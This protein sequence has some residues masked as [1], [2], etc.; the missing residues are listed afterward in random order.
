MATELKIAVDQR[1]AIALDYAVQADKS[2][3]LE[4][5]FSSEY[6]VVRSYGVEVLDHSPGCADLTRANTG[7][8]PLLRNH[9]QRELIG[10][11][12]RAWVDPATRKGRALVRFDKGPK[13][14]EAQRQVEAKILGN[15]SFWYK[16]RSYR[17]E[18]PDGPQSPPRVVIDKWE[19]VEISLVSCPDDPTVG[20]GRSAQPV[21]QDTLQINTGAAKK[22][23]VMLTEDIQRQVQEAQQAERERI[24]NISAMPKKWGPK[25]PGGMARAQEIAEQ[26]IVQGIPE[27]DARNLFSDA[28]FVQDVQSISRPAPELGLDDKEQRQYSLLRAVRAK[29]E[30]DWTNAGFEL[31]CSRAI[32]KETGGT[33]HGFY[34]PIKD[35]KVNPL[36]SKR[37]LALMEGFRATYTTGT[38]AAAGNLVATVLDA[39][40]FIDFLRS[41]PRVMQA[42][43]QMLSGLVGKLEIPRQNGAGTVYWVAEGSGP[44]DA[45]ATFDKVTFSPQTLGVLTSMTRLMMIQSTPDIEML[46]RQDIANII[47]LEIDRVG[48]D[49]TG[50]SSQPRGI[51]NTSGI[52]SVAMGT[53]GAAITYDA[54]IDVETTVATA[55]ADEGNLAYMTNPKVVGNLKKLKSTTN[56]YLWNGTDNPLTSGTPG[57]INGYPVYRTN[58]MPA[59]KTKGTGT[60]LSTIIFGDWSQLMYANWGVLD[61]LPNPYGSGYAA[62]NVEIRALQS[63]DVKLR[64]PESFAV[65]VDIVTS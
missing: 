56:E 22:M 42:G 25:L 35:L 12:E 21:Y 2:D 16:I 55:N 8:A 11:V 37:A 54:I 9:D 26:A 62:G 33:P 47:A 23:E 31:E 53:N 36:D 32:A 7:A 1:R 64:H 51:L 3:L 41:K 10:V 57:S 38:A 24:R 30:N 63:M 13:G 39:G 58:Q 52:G 40:S 43:A 34:V 18:Y 6:P 17:E 59:N 14:Q 28:L 15:V 44:T 60:N 29:L 50:T 65:I 4:L 48:I 49:G 19:V 46:A 20:V 61:I 45:N 5:S 27:Q